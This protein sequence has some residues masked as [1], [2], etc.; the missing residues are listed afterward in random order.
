MTYQQLVELLTELP[1]EAQD[2]NVIV[3][4]PWE[5]GY[6]PIEDVILISTRWNDELAEGTPFLRSLRQN[7][8]AA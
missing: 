5:D 1:Y 6:F 8:K 3:H 4:I 2:M 7:I